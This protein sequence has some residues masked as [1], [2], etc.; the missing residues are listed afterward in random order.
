M[1]TE[2]YQDHVLG[3]P[4]VCSNCFRL[5]RV[6]RLDP[7]RNGFGGE[8]ESHYER[9]RQTT[10]VDHADCGDEPTQSQAVFCHCGVESAR[11]RIWSSPEV[12]KDRFREMLKN[13]LRS[14]S[15]KEISIRQK[16]AAACAIQLFNDGAGVDE[17]LATGIEAGI[18]AQM[19]AGED[20][21]T[22]D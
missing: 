20:R 19:A 1:P 21:M 5:I 6:E 10:E 4:D 16:E 14:L 13:V 12:G 8:L 18:V 11:H 22:A 17:S 3:A 15:R 7:T 9:V 2:S